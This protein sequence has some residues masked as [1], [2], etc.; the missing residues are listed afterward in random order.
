MGAPRKRE[1]KI[2]LNI[3]VG[4]KIRAAGHRAAYRRGRSLSE[5]ITEFIER[6]ARE[7]HET[8]NNHAPERKPPSRK[9]VRGKRLAR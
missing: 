9:T 6:M 4:A 5:L 7:D 2:P 8:T 3:T 1:R